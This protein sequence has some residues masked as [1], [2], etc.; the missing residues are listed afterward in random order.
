ML[1]RCALS[2]GVGVL[3]LAG[4]CTP[5]GSTAMEKRDSILKMKDQSLPGFTMR[6]TDLESAIANSYGYAVISRDDLTLL[7]FGGG[8][9]YGVATV[10]KTGEQRFLKDAHGALNLGI[11]WRDYRGLYIFADQAAFDGFCAGSWDL[12]VRAEVA[13]ASRDRGFEQSAEET[14]LPR[15]RYYEYTDAGLVLHVGL[16]LSHVM[17]WWELDN[18]TSTRAPAR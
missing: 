1:L 10:R 2:F 11:G 9:G 17:P 13:V 7:W 3:M 16:P 6:H 14:A 8:G 15:V 4:C 18:A 12:G 5:Q